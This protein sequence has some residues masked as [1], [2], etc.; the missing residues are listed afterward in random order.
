LLE[1]ALLRGMDAAREDERWTQTRETNISWAVNYVAKL[2]AA[3]PD[4]EVFVEER[5]YFPQNVV[6]RDEASGVADIRAHSLA[7]GLGW[8]IDYKNGVVGVDDPGENDQLWFYATAAFW[9]MPLDRIRLVIVQPNGIGIPTIRETEISSAD[10]I[11]FRHDIERLILEAESHDVRLTPGDWCSGCAVG[12]E[13]SARERAAIA[14]MTGYEGTFEGLLTDDLPDAEELDRHRWASIKQKAAFVRSF[15][16][17]VDNAA[18][19]YALCG[20]PVPGFKIVE[21]PGHRAF[22]GDLSETAQALAAITGKTPDAFIDVSLVG[23]TEAEKAV[24]EVARLS[25]DPSRVNARFAELVG[26]KESGKVALVPESDPRPAFNKAA[27]SFS[28][29]VPENL[30]PD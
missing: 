18:Y 13:C 11:S 23:I 21:Q 2:G 3:Y 17:D 1:I 20:G 24:K 15:L 19:R 6:K 10:L 16:N 14:A 12:A 9:E 28:G 5:V 29:V 22:K 7:A 4:L 30:I 25:P 27:S 26:R 8:L